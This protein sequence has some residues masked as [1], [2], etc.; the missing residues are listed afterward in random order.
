MTLPKQKQ[1]EL[2]YLLLYAIEMGSDSEEKLIQMVSDEL[3][4]AKSHLRAAYKEALSV[5][6]RAA[7]IDDALSTISTQ[8]AYSRIQSVEKTI[9]RLACYDLLFTQS[10]HEKVV[11]SEALRL[12]KKFATPASVS[13]VNAILDHLYKKKRGEPTST[14]EV[15]ESF[16]ALMESEK[17]HENRDQE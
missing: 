17:A 12:A 14:K 7:K 4:I 13:F 1:Y 3:K 2:I 6:E 15:E 5:K 16:T 8:F 11:I 10:L 9:L